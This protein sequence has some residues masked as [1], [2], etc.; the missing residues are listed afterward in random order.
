MF[1]DIQIVELAGVLAGPAVG[2]F[3]AE[4]GA[5]VIKIEN[6]ETNGDV[7]RHWKL[8]NEDPS[9]NTSAYFA[10]VNYKKVTCF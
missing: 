1:K 8:P 5:T 2:A 9:A 4:L 7:T 3:F 10:S 6:P